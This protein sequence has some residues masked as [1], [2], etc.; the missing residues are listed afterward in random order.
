GGRRACSMRCS[1]L[2]RLSIMLASLSSL[3]A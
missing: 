1:T 2:F 3:T